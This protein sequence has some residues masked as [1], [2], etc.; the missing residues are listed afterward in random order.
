MEVGQLFYCSL[1]G[2]GKLL[3]MIGE[4]NLK[5]FKCYQC[6]CAHELLVRVDPGA[7]DDELDDNETLD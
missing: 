2:S 4:D 3:T 7:D 6:G 5:Y 1:C